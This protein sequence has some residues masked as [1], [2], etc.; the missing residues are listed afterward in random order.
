LAD[1]RQNGSPHGL[2]SCLADFSSTLYALQELD[3]AEKVLREALTLSRT[4][5]DPGAMGMVLNQ[6]GLVAVARGAYAEAQ[7]LFRESF[8]LFHEGGNRWYRARVGNNL[9]RTLLALGE[10]DQAQAFY[11]VALAMALEV[12]A[13]PVAL[14][15][16]LGLATVAIRAEAWTAAL[17]I[18][19]YLCQ[20]PATDIEMQ[21]RAEQ[22][23]A[24][25]AAHLAPAQWATAEAGA[26]SRT[27][28]D[29]LSR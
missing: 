2:L 11:R 22:L 26:H 16:L 29:F 28:Q 23:R 15:A 5:Q 13:I 19:L 27:L 24:E 4:A 20:R 21:R 6:L 25:V 8:A 17:D 7:P 1:W 10:V 12:Q 18:L 9:G 14:E 3:E